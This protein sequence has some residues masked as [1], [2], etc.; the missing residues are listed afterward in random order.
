MTA[1]IGGGWGTR[2]EGKGGSDIDADAVF[3]HEIVK[4]INFKISLRK[5][6]LSL[7][8][9]ASGPNFSFLTGQQTSL[10]FCDGD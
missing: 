1:F 5:I 8:S 2:I 4:K 3:I 9:L 6:T 7:Y 10:Y